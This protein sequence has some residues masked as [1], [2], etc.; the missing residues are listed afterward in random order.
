MTI[1]IYSTT[2]ELDGTLHKRKAARFELTIA[3]RR[4]TASK[5]VMKRCD[6]TV[7]GETDAAVE[8]FAVYFAQIVL[9]N[10][11]GKVIRFIK[12][13]GHYRQDEGIPIVPVNRSKYAVL[14]VSPDPANEDGIEATNLNV[15][16]PWWNGSVATLEGL[17]GVHT[18]GADDACL[19]HLRWAEQAEEELEAH[20][21]DTLRGSKLVNMDRLFDE[22][23]TSDNLADGVADG[24]LGPS[25]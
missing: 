5:P 10:T 24:V 2:A 1:R 15:F 22:P 21:A 13:L 16:I 6:F 3:V 7:C 25:V 12:I 4:N 9:A 8:G 20:F 18:V 23:L 11:D 19:G 14:G 17:G